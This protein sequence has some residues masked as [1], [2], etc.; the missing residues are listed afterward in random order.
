M[1]A[2]DSSGFAA[3]LVLP[4]MPPL[5]AALGNALYPLPAPF[6]YQGDLG[7]FTLRP[8]QGAAAF[9]PQAVCVLGWRGGHWLLGMDNTDVVRLHPAL[10]GVSEN[11][12]LPDFLLPALLELVFEPLLARLSLA[13]GEDVHW[14][15][16][17]ETPP[18]QEEALPLECV[19]ESQGRRAVTLLSLH[20]PHAEAVSDLAL[21]LRP[22]RRL[23]Q[24][25]TVNLPV[26]IQAGTVRLGMA[27][28]SALA[29]GDVLLPD[30]WHLS[31]G[32]ALLVLPPA[33]D[34]QHR[35]LPCTLKG[36]TLTV[37]GTPI[38][39]SPEFFM[40]QQQ[41]PPTESAPE[42]SPCPAGIAAA[43]EVD[44]CFELEH[45]LMTVDEVA[46][47]QPGCTLALGVDAQ[48]PVTLRV[49]GK[50]LGTG[51]LVDVDGIV[52]VQI[53]SRS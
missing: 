15:G 4:S 36:R 33:R 38:V 39:T 37:E 34:G 6:V 52:G 50:M 49:Q 53:L 12:P 35:V 3:P 22:W 16:M 44:V 47:L 30:Q 51:R 5:R 26:S 40:E 25:A 46:A 42:D 2:T 29:P 28:C 43:W 8:L 31:G 11:T 18:P 23:S 14:R 45:R 10:A 20:A 1:T 21:A 17:A 24:T 9:R 19:L 48:S 27:E 41:T 13:L 32:R 7:A